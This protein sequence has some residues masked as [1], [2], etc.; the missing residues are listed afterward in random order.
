MEWG[1]G[2]RKIGH[3]EY[4]LHT[5]CISEYLS[6]KDLLGSLAYYHCLTDREIEA[7]CLKSQKAISL[8]QGTTVFSMKWATSQ[9]PKGQDEVQFIAEGHGWLLYL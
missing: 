6:P 4:F 8:P 9:I 1:G 2:C 3:L 5:W 7:L